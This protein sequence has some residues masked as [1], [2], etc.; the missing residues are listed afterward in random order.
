LAQVEGLT[1]VR[2]MVLRSLSEIAD[3]CTVP[4]AEGAFYFL[5]KVDSDLQPLEVTRRLVEE[6]KVAVIP[7]MTF[8]LEGCYL[9]LSYGALQ[10]DFVAAGMERLV[11]GLRAILTA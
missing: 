8:G 11:R 6:F 3:I 2:E 9:R 10:A 4:T 1:D 5:V 7:G